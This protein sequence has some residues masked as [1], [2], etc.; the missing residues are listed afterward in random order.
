MEGRGTRGK[1]RRV[2]LGGLWW[3]GDSPVGYDPYSSSGLGDSGLSPW[4]TQLGP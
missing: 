4:Q 1:L 2:P 3:V